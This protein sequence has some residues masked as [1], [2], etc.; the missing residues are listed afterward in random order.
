MRRTI[1]FLG[2]VVLVLTVLAASPQAGAITYGVH[3]GEGHQNVGALIGSFDRGDGVYELFQMCTGALMAPDLF[4]TATHC[5]NWGATPDMLFVSFETDLNLQ[6]DWSVQPA[7]VIGVTRFWT[8]PDFRWGGAS[9]AYND[10]AVVELA[11][12]VNLTP[13][14]LPPVGYLSEL[15][16][17]GGLRGKYVVNAGYGDQVP[18]MPSASPFYSAPYDGFRWTSSSRFSA[19]TPYHLF[20]LANH[21]ATGG[22][23]GCLGDSGG[24]KF[25]GGYVVAVTTSADPNCKALNQNQRLDTPEVD[26]F[27]DFVLA[28]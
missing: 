10:V 20:L 5:L 3:D 18:S 6:E 11:S 27:L 13:V 23:G 12:S 2:A 4:L 8:H 15:A 26:T 24:P 19:L 16:A 17:A 25:Y 21:A 14:V 1:P 22:G 7:Q 9:T 28:Q